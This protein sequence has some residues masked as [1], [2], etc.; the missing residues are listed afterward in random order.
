MVVNVGLEQQAFQILDSAETDI[1]WHII[2]EIDQFVAIE[3][4]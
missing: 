4:S 1:D 3:T 2:E